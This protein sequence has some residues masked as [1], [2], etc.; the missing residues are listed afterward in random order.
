VYYEGILE[1]TK[2]F[3]KISNFRGTVESLRGTHLRK[4]DG[5]NTNESHRTPI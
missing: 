4:P 3:V 2:L 5:L 1:K